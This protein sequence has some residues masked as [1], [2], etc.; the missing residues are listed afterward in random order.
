MEG[1]EPQADAAR[2]VRLDRDV[3][4]RAAQHVLD[5]DGLSAF[6]LRRIGSELGADPTAIYRHFRDKDEL[7][8]EL[9]DQGLWGRNPQAGV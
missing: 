2:G 7:V 3:I 5:E 8:I 4:L 9:A 6:T 1:G